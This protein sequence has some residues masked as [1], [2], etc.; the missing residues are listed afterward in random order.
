M[1]GPRWGAS[2]VGVGPGVV[3]RPRPPVCR[4]AR[5]VLPRRLQFV[6]GSMYATDRWRTADTGRGKSLG[7]I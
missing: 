4:A 7:I 6:G 5:L 1:S 2:G 3:V